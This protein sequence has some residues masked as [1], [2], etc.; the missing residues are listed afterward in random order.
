MNEIVEITLKIILSILALF[1]AKEIVN[2]I[3]V[4]I[5]KSQTKNKLSVDSSENIGRDKVVIN[6]NF[7]GIGD[8]N[9]ITKK[10]T[11]KKV[12]MTSGSP[13]NVGLSLVDFSHEQIELFGNFFQDFY[14]KLNKKRN[15][16]ISRNAFTMFKG[17]I[18]ALGT[19]NL[20]NDEWKEHCASSL[21]EIFHAWGGRDR[22]Y[23]DFDLI[24]NITRLRSSSGEKDIE[25]SNLFRDFWLY[26]E[27]FSGIDHHEP[28]K[29]IFS[30]QKILKNESIK[31]QD[32]YTDEI[33]LEQ[34]NGYFS[35]ITK[36]IEYSNNL[37][38]N[39]T[40]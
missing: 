21:R 31:L 3:N 4:R 36:I 10:Q 39:E 27:Y 17:G 2:Q 5:S 25:L 15:S 18:F 40:N 6:Y 19:N 23:S 24:Y 32:C 37:S 7:P 22:L 34:V 33:F 1:G 12:D 13:Y 29:V 26:Y 16:K 28:D 35:K 30:L 11:S 38:R 8:P 20:G 14:R 9:K